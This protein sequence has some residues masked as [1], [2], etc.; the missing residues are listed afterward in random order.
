MLLLGGS[1]KSH[2]KVRLQERDDQESPGGRNHQV[3][4]VRASRLGI[5]ERH[6]EGREKDFLCPIAA[7]PLVGSGLILVDTS[8]IS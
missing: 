1:G 2:G 4:H 5:F 3:L 7:Q 8:S 6:V